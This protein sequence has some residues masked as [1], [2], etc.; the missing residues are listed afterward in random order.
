M[1]VEKFLSIKL[2]RR[3]LTLLGSLSSLLL[4]KILV[5]LQQICGSV[6]CRLYLWIVV[7]FQVRNQLVANPIP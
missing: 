1:V 3:N 7:L 2:M 5:S 4:D 6:Q